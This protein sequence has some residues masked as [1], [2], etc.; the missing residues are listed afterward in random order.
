MSVHA[1]VDGLLHMSRSPQPRPCTDRF[2]ML[3]RSQRQSRQQLVRQSRAL[4]HSASCECLLDVHEHECDEVGEVRIGDVGSVRLVELQQIGGGQTK[5]RQRVQSLVH[6]IADEHQ[7]LADGGGGAQEQ[8]QKLGQHATNGRLELVVL[9]AAR[10]HTQRGTVE[11]SDRRSASHR[12]SAFPSLPV[13]PRVWASHL[14][15]RK[16]VDSS[17]ATSAASAG[18]RGTAD[19]AGD[20]APPP[21]LPDADDMRSGRREGGEGSVRAEQT[22][23]SEWK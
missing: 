16:R 23:R 19:A 18:D 10:P 15:N 5:L 6:V 3:R 4:R 11:A 7:M 22:E 21:P 20:E 8:R 13:S 1:S 12:H 9:A 17:T 2:P 14:A